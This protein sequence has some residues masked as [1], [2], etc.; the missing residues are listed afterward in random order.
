MND[1]LRLGFLGA[2]RGMT[3]AAHIR[4]DYPYARVAAICEAYAPLCEKA[5]DFF[6]DR[7]EEVECYTD[8]D[9]FLDESGIDALII[10]NFANAHAPVAIRALQKGIHVFS[11]VMPTQ[12]LAEAVQLCDAVERS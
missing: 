12:T 7:G 9:R 1:R 3:Y 5:R 11:E 10:A 4:P 2:S 8:L 6:R